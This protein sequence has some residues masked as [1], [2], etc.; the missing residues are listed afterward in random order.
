MTIRRLSASE[1]WELQR[2]QRNRERRRE[3]L[4]CIAFAAVVVMGLKMVGAL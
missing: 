2:R 3:W 4:A 1:R